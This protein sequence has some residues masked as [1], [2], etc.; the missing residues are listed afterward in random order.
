MAEGEK[1][2]N[3]MG[4]MMRHL[5]VSGMALFSFTQERVARRPDYFGMELSNGLPS[6]LMVW[7]RES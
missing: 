7:L 4:R 1:E 3:E 2:N 5:R 6:N